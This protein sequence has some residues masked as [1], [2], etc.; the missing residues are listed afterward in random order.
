MSAARPRQR[1]GMG[2]RGGTWKLG[3]EARASSMGR[4]N[5]NANATAQQRRKSADMMTMM[6]LRGGQM[7]GSGSGGGGGRGDPRRNSTGTHGVLQKAYLE[8]LFKGEGGEEDA[9]SALSERTAGKKRP[10]PPAFPRPRCIPPRDSSAAPAAT[11]AVN[12]AMPGRMSG[13]MPRRYSDQEFLR[14]LREANASAEVKVKVKRAQS[15]LDLRPTRR[16]DAMPAVVGG[17]HGG[18]VVRAHAMGD[19]PE[20]L[21]RS[22]KEEMGKLPPPRRALPRRNS[23]QNLRNSH[24]PGGGNVAPASPLTRSFLSNSHRE[25]LGNAGKPDTAARPRQR[26][27]SHSLDSSNHDHLLSE[28][29]GDEV[30]DSALG[31]ALGS[32]NS[33]E[34]V[35]GDAAAGKVWKNPKYDDANVN[36]LVEKPKSDRGSADDCGTHCA[37]MDGKSDLESLDQTDTDRD[38]VPMKVGGAGTESEEK[39]ATESERLNASHRQTN[40]SAPPPAAEAPKAAARPKVTRDKSGS[41]LFAVP[42]NKPTQNPDDGDATKKRPSMAPSMGTTEDV[43]ETTREIATIDPGIPTKLTL[44]SPLE[45]DEDDGCVVDRTPEKGFRIS[46]AVACAAC[47]CGCLCLLIVG[48]L[49]GILV[50]FFFRG[51]TLASVVGFSSGD[52]RGDDAGLDASNVTEGVMLHPTSY[53][54]HV[55]TIH[56]SSRPSALTSVAPS[57]ARQSLPPS[58]HPSSRLMEVISVAPSSAWHSS[59]PSLSV[60]PSAWPSADSFVVSLSLE[61]TPTS[62]PSSAPSESTSSLPSLS[63]P[64]TP[65]PSQLPS[66]SPTSS[67]GCPSELLKSVALGDSGALTMKYEVVLYEGDMEEQFGGLLCVSLEYEAAA[68]WIGLAFSEATRDPDFGRKEA[69]IGL[70]G[71]KASS[72]VAN[73]DGRASLGQ[74]YISMEGGPAFVNPG[75]YEIPAGGMKDGFSGPSMTLLSDIDKQTLINGSVFT[76]N[77]YLANPDKGYTRMTFSKYLREP[78]EIE[79]DPFGETILFYAVSPIVDFGEYDGKAE[80]MYTQLKLL[81]VASEEAEPGRAGKRNRPHI[82]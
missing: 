37:V 33:D 52:N 82:S 22:L 49:T 69:V 45:G 78:D 55:P 79:I 24:R 63:V 6:D 27:R 61:M 74:Q 77:S 7:H 38:A 23:D 72:A 56:H 41:K 16:G 50:M 25:P 3:Q 5:A 9:L 39:G 75:K 67:P 36:L 65:S 47:L 11:N 66:F 46:R 60:Q 81:D 70:P 10:P 26:K 42:A 54:S 80:W 76:V 34:G 62:L 43:S 51:E 71:L 73:T 53:P 58:L 15:G 18:R 12:E 68:G 2:G 28:I 14:N 21:S 31:S 59:S 1:P 40:E 35:N 13:K 4:L 48:G 29:H 64:P 19:R 8:G 30:L 17:P 20:R 44:T 57:S 32:V